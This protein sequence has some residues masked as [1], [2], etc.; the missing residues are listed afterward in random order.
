M[1]VLSKKNLSL[2]LALSLSFSILTSQ[3][4][5]IYAA[6]PEN[7]K[8]SNKT[9][10]IENTQ[11]IIL[12]KKQKNLIKKIKVSKNKTVK[13][14]LK[15]DLALIQQQIKSITQTS[16][17]T[18]III[19]D[20]VGTSTNSQNTK[21][22]GRCATNDWVCL[23]G[24]CSAAG[25]GWFINPKGTSFNPGPCPAGSV[26]ASSS[27]N[28][29]CRCITNFACAGS[30]TNGYTCPADVA[31][32]SPP[33]SINRCGQ[34]CQTSS[35]VLSDNSYPNP[36]MVLVTGTSGGVD[37]Y[38]YLTCPGGSSGSIISFS[39]DPY[40]YCCVTCEDG[41][42]PNPLRPMSGNCPAN[43]VPKTNAL[44]NT[45]NH[46][47]CY[48]C[49][50][51][52]WP[53]PNR[54]GACMIGTGVATDAT[55]NCCFDCPA[56]T[57]QRP[58]PIMPCPAGTTISSESDN[59]CSCP[60]GTFVNYN[61]SMTCQQNDL[62]YPYSLSL[63]PPEYCCFNCT[64]GSIPNTNRPGNCPAGSNPTDATKKCCTMSCPYGTTTNSDPTM[65]CM[66]S[67]PAFPESYYMDADS[68]F[69]NN[70]CFNCPDGTMANPE[71]MMA[72]PDDNPI[73]YNIIDNNCCFNCP[74]GTTR[75]GPPSMACPAGT[76]P[77]GPQG[78]ENDCCFTC[79]DGYEPNLYRPNCP[80]GYVCTE[81]NLCSFSCPSGYAANPNILQP[82]RPT[83]GQIYPSC[84]SNWVASDPSM[85]CCYD[86][87]RGGSYPSSFPNPNGMGAC[88]SYLLGS[89]LCCSC[90][91]LDIRN[92]DQTELTP[93]ARCPANQA[94][95]DPDSRC[96]YNCGAGYFPNP[97]G[98]GACPGLLIGYMT[99]N[100]CCA[101][102]NGFT[103]NPI[104]PDACGL[105]EIPS[106]DSHS[107]CFTC[108]TGSMANPDHLTMTCMQAF[109][110]LPY[111]TYNSPSNAC[112]FA[113]P[114][115]SRPMPTYGCATGEFPDSNNLC[116]Y[117]C[118]DGYISNPNYMAGLTPPADCP[119]GYTESDGTKRC[120]FNTNCTSYNLSQTYGASCMQIAANDSTDPNTY[121]GMIY[122]LTG[123]PPGQY[124]AASTPVMS[125]STCIC[126]TAVCGNGIIETGEECELSASSSGSTCAGAQ[127]CNDM[128]MC[129]LG[130]CPVGQSPCGSGVDSICCQSS[131]CVV[132]MNVPE[133]CSGANEINCMGLP[134]I[135]LGT[136]FPDLCCN[137]DNCKT[138]I[139]LQIDG[140]GMVVD[141]SMLFDTSI[142]VC[143]PSSS[144][145]PFASFKLCGMD[146]NDAM[147]CGPNT[148]CILGACCPNIRAC[149]P[150]NNPNICCT[151]D[152]ICDWNTRTC[153]KPCSSLPI[154]ACTDGACPPFQ[155]CM[156]NNGVN[157]TCSG[158]TCGDGTIDHHVWRGSAAITLLDD[159]QCDDGN[160]LDGDGCSCNCLLECGDLFCN[161][162]IENCSNCP[163][164]CTGCATCG[165]GM[166]D[167]GEQC[168]PPNTAGCDSDCKKTLF[169]PGN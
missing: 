82:N 129:V 160:T 14:K 68:V 112:C 49:Q 61:S 97:N 133:C 70:C 63:T 53:N 106:D 121:N 166:I 102:P 31:P 143:C 24:I 50:A 161:P 110:S 127:V 120:C 51:G 153:K 155:S 35:P 77:G 141:P 152:E 164:D 94:P 3:T 56:G 67:L 42:T 145:N 17:D 84:P 87:T 19:T 124:C 108:P 114:T 111:D 8:I 99:D 78:R 5:F 85:I 138:I 163:S 149:G 79:P 12:K 128:C 28:F 165:N 69:N 91:G 86:C 119:G 151:E 168:E 76:N 154:S 83:L 93:D 74:A 73:S 58:D 92:P 130:G 20:S 96:C 60:R 88:P 146:N 158:A 1:K 27:Y 21:Q 147:C 72:C 157:C 52:S 2:L 115:G 18:N 136:F 26:V 140:T 162:N 43:S 33:G 134:T 123:C 15:Q 48:M 135:P 122:D 75:N 25:P 142:Q 101:C 167:P 44:S 32:M 22:P 47:C 40:N 39:T 29:C 169:C 59:C 116:C 9:L 95:V 126:R 150:A 4:N 159:E 104:S 16:S 41:Y 37:Y 11:L 66:E 125:N 105:N 54:P 148:K 13:E 45:L 65:T 57:F 107:C 90:R 10:S 23:H 30:V 62:Y 117:R 118:P 103:Q 71:P 137:Y 38:N 6:K 64:S 100:L 7:N 139:D 80:N 36:N 131:M 156:S 132:N 55:N 34:Q 113:C 98:T 46:N 109:P 89:G 81:S 144:G